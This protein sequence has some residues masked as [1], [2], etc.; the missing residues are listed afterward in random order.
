[1]CP[2]G[3]RTANLISSLGQVINAE[4]RLLFLPALWMF[5]ECTQ[6]KPR[7]APVPVLLL[8]LCW[9]RMSSVISAEI[10]RVHLLIY[11]YT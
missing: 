7:A 2:H 5:T 9:D 1:M 3:A 4:V 8:T 11:L 6:W 10:E